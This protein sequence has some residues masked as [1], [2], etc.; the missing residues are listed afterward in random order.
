MR[1]TPQIVE[2]AKIML[3]NGQ[4]WSPEADKILSADNSLCLCSYPDGAWIADTHGEV[5]IDRW[6]KLE[7]VIA[8]P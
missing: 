4:D 2:L 7:C 1:I 3:A 8:L 6:T 5:S